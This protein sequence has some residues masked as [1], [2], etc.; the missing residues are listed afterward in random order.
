MLNSRILIPG[1]RL[2]ILC[3]VGDQRILTELRE[4]WKLLRSPSA[5]Y[6]EL[7]GGRGAG[8]AAQ[9]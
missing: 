6:A 1:S 9:T 2:F 5:Y 3:F 7:S 8:V 4:P